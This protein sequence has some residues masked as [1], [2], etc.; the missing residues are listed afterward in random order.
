[1]GREEAGMRTC[2]HHLLLRLLPNTL[3]QGGPRGL[4]AGR[5]AGCPPTFILPRD[6][7]GWWE[8]DRGQAGSLDGL[9]GVDRLFCRAYGG[10]SV[11][12]YAEEEEEE[13]HSSYY[14]GSLSTKL[15]CIYSYRRRRTTQG[16]AR[17]CGVGI[18]RMTRCGI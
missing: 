16:W 3:R 13:R 1:V 15:S 14:V 9:G 18:C 8:A 4:P 2:H 12:S 7:C 5:R 6:G 17:C 10:I 11:S